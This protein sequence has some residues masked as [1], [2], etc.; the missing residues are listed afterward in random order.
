MKK[1]HSIGLIIIMISG[2]CYLI[3]FFAPFLN[4]KVLTFYDGVDQGERERR[5]TAVQ[6][7]TTAEPPTY[8]TNSVLT[9]GADQRE[10]FE[11]IKEWGRGNGRSLYFA[12]RLLA[13]VVFVPQ[14]FLWLRYFGRH[15]T[16]NLKTFMVLLLLFASGVIALLTSITPP[17]D[18][19]YQ[20]VSLIQVRFSEVS[21]AGGV[22]WAGVSL[23]LS[24]AGG[25]LS[26]G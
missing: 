21:L 10:D 12:A 7:I 14:L 25:R 5:Y 19:V 20:Q 22:W 15:S 1:R 24:M 23:L 4:A 16:L 9:L 18:L 26:N 11:V 17:I 8:F 13:L 3:A 6:I 2:L